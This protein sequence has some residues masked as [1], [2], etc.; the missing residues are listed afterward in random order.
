[1]PSGD[2]RAVFLPYCLERQEDGR[3]VVLNRDYKPIGF[4]TRDWVKYEDYPVRVK[5]KR[6][7]KAMAAKLS[8]DGK[9]DLDK[10]WL[11]KDGTVPIH[12]KANMRLYLT[13][14]EMLAKLAI[15]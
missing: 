13:K 9:Y 2:F 11:Y 5:F 15:V 3:Y 12:S 4:K 10:I 7:T 1:M 14:L 8:A 6:L